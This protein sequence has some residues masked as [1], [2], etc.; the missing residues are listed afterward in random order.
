MPGRRGRVG[1]LQLAP[2]R[3][4]RLRTAPTRSTCA[5]PIRRGMSI[6]LLRRAASRS[7]RPRLK[8]RSTAARLARPTTRRRP[9]HSRLT[10]RA[11]ASSAASMAARGARARAPRPPRRWWTAPTP[12]R[13]ARPIRPAMSTRPL[14]RAR[15]PSTR[16]HR[17]RRSTAALRPDERR[18]ADLHV[19]RQ[20]GGLDVRVP[21]RR[22]RAGSCSSAHTTASLADG[23]H[24]FDVRATDPAGNVDPSPRR[25]ASRSTRR[26][27]NDDRQ[28]AVGARRTTRR[29]HSPSRPAR[30]ARRSSAASTAARGARAHA[31][32]HRGADRRRPHVRGARHG[33]RRQRR[34]DAGVA[35]LHSRH[36]RGA[37]DDR[38]RPVRPDERRDADVHVLGRP[39]G[40]DVRVPG[41]RRRLGFL[42]LAASTTARS[43]TAP[44][45]SRCA[46]PIRPATLTRRPASAS[47]TVDT[48]APQ[49]D[50]RQRPVGPDGR[51]DAD[52]CV[53]GQPRPARASNAGST[54][55]RGARARR[56]RPLRR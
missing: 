26:H 41:R 44:T 7:T 31:Q 21:G 52:I 28:R 2:T 11:R 18:D 15:S 6:R 17:R 37:D 1:L 19:L 3:P 33:S 36:G 42:L 25:R 46:P 47:F 27:R 4:R 23:A 49:H 10:S 56:P 38:Q 9:S 45:P 35:Q 14:R 29:R 55:A 12:S 34:S 22:G 32:D 54:P 43:A 24:T 39:A 20:S 16:R 8:R 50:Y 5:Q 40:L 51:C 13:C 30:R 53:L 48:A